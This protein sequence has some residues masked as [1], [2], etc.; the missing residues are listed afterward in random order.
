MLLAGPIISPAAPGLVG[1]VS[2]ARLSVTAPIV[3]PAVTAV[4][5]GIFPEVK[6][7]TFAE[8]VPPLLTSM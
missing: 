2:Q 3:P 6:P 4:A 1:M 7:T 8:T 5:S